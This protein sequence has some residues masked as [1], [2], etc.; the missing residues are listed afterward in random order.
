MQLIENATT[1]KQPK[2]GADDKTVV[3]TSSLVED[4]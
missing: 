3:F 2:L 4:E 1:S